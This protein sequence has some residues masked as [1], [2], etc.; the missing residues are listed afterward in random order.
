M[1][2]Q[3]KFRIWS[4]S[5]EIYVTDLSLENIGHMTDT[6]NDLFTKSE[7]VYQQYTGLKDEN[8]KEIYEGDKVIVDTSLGVVTGCKFIGEIVWNTKDG[9]W[10]IKDIEN[11]DGRYNCDLCDFMAYCCTVIGHIYG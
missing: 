8:D 6:L 1:P 7:V 5:L 4:K 11:P 10:G 9:G 2:R 3:I